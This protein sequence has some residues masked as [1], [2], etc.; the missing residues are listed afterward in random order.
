MS[1]AL[2]GAFDV[3]LAGIKASWFLLRIELAWLALVP[4]ASTGFGVCDC[5]LEPPEADHATA[6]VPRHWRADAGPQR[7]PTAFFCQLLHF[8]DGFCV[9]ALCPA[10]YI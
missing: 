6:L 9:S 2:A 10:D 3:E 8:R 4:G 1:L 7:P 5:R